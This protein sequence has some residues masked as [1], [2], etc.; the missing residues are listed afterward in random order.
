MDK[1]GM[2]LYDVDK[3]Q[4]G[5]NLFSDTLYR[6][7]TACSNWGGRLPGVHRFWDL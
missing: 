1:Q 5:L 7:M 6:L 2:I 3:S 4:I